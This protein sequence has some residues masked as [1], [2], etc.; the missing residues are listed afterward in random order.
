MP[1][2][3]SKQVWTQQP[4]HAVEIDWANPL[5]KDLIAAFVFSNGLRDLVTG[6][7]AENKGG[8]FVDL[9]LIHI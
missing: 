9:S 4:Q 1:L 8:V 2:I 7:F 6:Q 3:T 5:S